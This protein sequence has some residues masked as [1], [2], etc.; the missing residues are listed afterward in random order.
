MTQ[1]G[2]IALWEEV[3]DEQRRKLRAVK[4]QYSDLEAVDGG[5]SV[6]V[7][8]SSDDV[9]K[10]RSELTSEE[11]LR[12]T[13][14]KSQQQAGYLEDVFGDT[15]KIGL[16]ASVDPTSFRNSGS[17]TIDNTQ[18]EAILRRQKNALTRLRSGQTTN[19]KLAVCLADPASIEIDPPRNLPMVNQQ[20]LELNQINA[21]ER[22]LGTRD[23]YLLQG[24]PGTG[25]TTVIAELVL[26]ILDQSQNQGVRILITSQSNVAVNNALDRIVQSRPKSKRCSGAGWSRGKSWFSGTTDAQSTARRMAYFT[27]K[28]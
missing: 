5:N 22:A 10:A 24:P 26:Q 28:R 4:F 11:L 27:E 15:L 21:V 13:G 17:I 1:I 3:V 19:P 20:S 16:A 18:A 2:Q 8:L 14:E 9:E 7:K 25:K 23:L 12:L 6:Q